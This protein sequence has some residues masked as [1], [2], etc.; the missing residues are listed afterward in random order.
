MD[1]FLLGVV[2]SFFG[3]LLKE[4]WGQY[5]QR[6]RMAVAFLSEIQSLLNQF[7]M[8]GGDKLFDLS[9]GTATFMLVDENFFIIY[10]SNANILGIFNEQLAGDIVR[11][12]VNAKGFV[13]TIKTWKMIIIDYRNPDNMKNVDEYAIVGKEH[14]ASVIEDADIVIKGLNDAISEKYICWAISYFCNIVKNFV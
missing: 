11:L 9:N 14:Y 12:Y 6:K 3:F 4:S 13:C 5:I 1:L 8:V 7:K 2:S 10:D